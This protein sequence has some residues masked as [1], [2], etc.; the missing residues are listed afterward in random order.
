MLYLND[1]RVYPQDKLYLG[2]A[3]LEELYCNNVLVWKKADD[4]NGLVLTHSRTQAQVTISGTPSIY[5]AVGN[6]SAMSNF[7]GFSSSYGDGWIG[8]SSNVSQSGNI[9]FSEYEAITI[10]YGSPFSI[11]AKIDGTEVAASACLRFVYTGSN[12]R[13]SFRIKVEYNGSTITEPWRVSVKFPATT[14][15][16]Q[17]WAVVWTVKNP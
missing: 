11:T 9:S 10:T 8:E 6:L 5:A 4:L 1:T 3:E 17:G 15:P 16:A 13:W 14:L 12:Q 2:N 7:V